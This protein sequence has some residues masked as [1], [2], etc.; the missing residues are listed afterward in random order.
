MKVPVC[1]LVTRCVGCGGSDCG[2]V[3]S[4]GG[5]SG[6]A[7]LPAG[8]AFLITFAVF[9][10]FRVCRKEVVMETK[11]ISEQKEKCIRE[12]SLNYLHVN[13]CVLCDMRR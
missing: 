13:V 7:V 12:Q 6:G 10:N 9:F 11:E 4:D 5:G 2:D 3:S 1:L 8:A